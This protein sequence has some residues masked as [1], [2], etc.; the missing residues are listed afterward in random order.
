MSNMLSLNSTQRVNLIKRKVGTS[1]SW[2]TVYTYT[3]PLEAMQNAPDTSWT[4]TSI[5]L[6]TFEDIV[7]YKIY[8]KVWTEESSTAPMIIWDNRPQK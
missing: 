7:Y 1:G 6:F 3:V 4:D 2:S 5:N 8:G